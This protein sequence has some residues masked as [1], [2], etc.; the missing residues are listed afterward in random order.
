M[1]TREC[2]SHVL[3]TSGRRAALALV[4]LL[5]LTPGLA[6]GATGTASG[7]A[8]PFPSNSQPQQGEIYTVRLSVTNTS[9]SSAG[10][11]FSVTIPSAKILL[12]CNQSGCPAGSGNGA[13]VF[14]P[15][16]A[17]QCEA[18]TDP[19]VTGCTAGT[20]PTSGA[21]TVEATT[22]RT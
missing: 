21:D 9:Q 14:F 15:T 1:L 3:W 4:L 22:D 7:S 12:D 5:I 13:V 19:C 10:N 16:N 18:G 6:W 20:D 8:G 17:G 2:P 11:F